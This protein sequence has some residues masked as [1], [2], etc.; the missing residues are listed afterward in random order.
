M[1]LFTFSLIVIVVSTLGCST[2]NPLC[3]DNYCVEGEIYARSELADDA[4]FSKLAIDDSV[5]L[6]TLVS[7][8]TP[9]ETAPDDAKTTDDTVTLADIVTDVASNGVNSSYKG[10]TVTITAAVKFTFDATETRNSGVTLH[11][12]NE[13]ISFFVD[14]SD[15]ADDLAHLA[16]GTSYT[17]TLFIRNV[18][19]ST[20]NP[21]RTNIWSNVEERPTQVDINIETVSMT[22][23]VTDV[24]AGGTRYLS[25]TVRMQ[26]VVSFDLLKEAGLISL[27]TN[28]ASVSFSVIDIQNPEKLNKYT[29]N[30][31]YFFTLYIEKIEEDEEEPGKYRISAGIADD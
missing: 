9:V 11:T 10:Q 29:A 8:P 20:S 27:S 2:E 5:I 24:A 1:K 16:N 25:K 6:A 28:N 26:A 4:A 23:I 7:T 19:T 15:G 22:Q 31:S 13:Q 21:E 17:F 14:D 3:T 30:I 12:H 18:A